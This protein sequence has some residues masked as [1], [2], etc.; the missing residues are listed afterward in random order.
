M[1]NGDSRLAGL[2]IATVVTTYLI[3]L[4]GIYTA[5]SG[6]G[7]TC[8]GRWPLCDG[9]VFGLFPANWPSFIEW[10]HRLVAMI[11]GFLIA[12]SAIATWRAG[13]SRPVVLPLTFAT[14]LLPLQIWIGGQTV[15]TYELLVLTSHFLVALPIFGAVII[16]ITWHFAP[17]RIS[18]HSLR[19]LFGGALILVPMFWAIG[20]RMAF[21]HT[22]R[23]QVAYYAM[24][25]LL[26]ATMVMAVVL[27]IREG[28]HTVKH[29]QLLLASCVV[30]IASLVIILLVGRLVYTTTLQLVD[31][32]ATALLFSCLVLAVG[33]LML[34]ERGVQLTRSMSSN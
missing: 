7:L 4:L 9:A 34:E 16:G 23:I 10:F 18:R 19:R 8:E 24:G 13:L 29:P 17:S 11:G 33:L 1:G 28:G 21:T 32:G 22:P 31:W 27:I 26:L 30:S 12:G 15:L 20:P 25:V 2:L 6:A 3:V 14:L 5:A